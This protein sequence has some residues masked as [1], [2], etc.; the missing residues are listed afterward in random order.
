MLD[1]PNAIAT[2]QGSINF[3]DE[4]LHLEMRPEPKRRRVASLTTPFAITGDLANP[5][6]RVSTVG[7]GGRMIGEVA[8]SPVNV[9]GSLVP[10]VG[11]RGRDNNNP[12]LNLSYVTLEP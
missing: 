5:S 2:G 8:L 1:T 9:L 4:T 6:V 3:A 10:F 11:D 7:A 12:C